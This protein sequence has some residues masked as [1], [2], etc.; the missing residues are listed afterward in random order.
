VRIERAADDEPQAIRDEDDHVMV[1]EDLR[2]FLE[3]RARFGI[4]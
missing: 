3:Q 2:V 4:F 1:F